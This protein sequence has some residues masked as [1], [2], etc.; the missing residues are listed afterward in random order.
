M[1]DKALVMHCSPTLAGLKS[2]NIFNYSFTCADQ[3]LTE[4]DSFRNALRPKG[5]SLR[6]L[7]ICGDRALIYVYRRDKV[8][9]ELRKPDVFNFLSKYGYE[10]D[11]IDDCIDRLAGR[12]TSQLDFP[13][14]IGL[15]LGYPLA[16]VIGFIENKGQNCRCTGCWKVYCNECE[17]RK[18]FAKFDKCKAIYC[19]LFNRGL[20]GIEQLTVAA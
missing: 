5:V 3:L 18:Q 8:Q 4:L 13:H 9:D 20:R 7:R 14:E 2:A 12:I 1:I 15:F 17:A 11:R 10:T 6:I 19:D 16:D